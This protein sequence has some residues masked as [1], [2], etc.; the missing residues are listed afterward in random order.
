MKDPKR[1]DIMRAARSGGRR[2]PAAYAAPIAPG[3]YS[4]LGKRVEAALAELEI[5]AARAWLAGG[6]EV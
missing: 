2:R 1:S 4:E 6:G 5:A 3:P